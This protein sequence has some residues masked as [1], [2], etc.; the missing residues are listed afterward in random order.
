V[1]DSVNRGELRVIVTLPSGEA[2]VL[3]FSPIS[4]SDTPETLAHPT[5]LCLAAVIA[6]LLAAGVTSLRGIAD[7]LNRRGIRTPRGVG[8]WQSG[9]VA[10]L[11]KRLPA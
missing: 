5:R 11:L 1:V 4:L 3:Y 8:Q 7:E 10:E 2:A 6:E 9:T